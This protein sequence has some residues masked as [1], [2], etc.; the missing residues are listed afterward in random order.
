WFYST[1]WSNGNLNRQPNGANTPLLGISEAALTAP[2]LTILLGDGSGEQGTA[3]YAV[4][5]NGNSA[6]SNSTVKAL[7]PAWNDVN[8]PARLPGTAQRHFNGSCYA[9]ADGHVKFLPA[10]TAELT[11]SI[12]GGFGVAA[13]SGGKPTFGT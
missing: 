13:N 2:S 11:H 1:Y 4:C 9:F 8:S 7:C 6:G 5:G 3:H 12:T 10:V